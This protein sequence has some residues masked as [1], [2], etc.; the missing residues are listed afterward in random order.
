[1]LVRYSAQQLTTDQWQQN[2]TVDVIQ[3]ANMDEDISL[4]AGQFST[5]TL[6]Q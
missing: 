1:M 6:M 4:I 2:G 5:E 3:G